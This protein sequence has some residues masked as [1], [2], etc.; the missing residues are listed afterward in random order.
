[1]KSILNDSKQCIEQ[2]HM[3][4]KPTNSHKCMEVHYTHRIPST[5]LGHSC[6][7]L[8][9]GALRRIPTSKYYRH[10]WNQC[11]DI[12]LNFKNNTWFKI[13]IKN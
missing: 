9:G 12:N 3:I 10:F 5:C 4:T 2:L 13:C 11:T 6:G 8:H 1:M 7:H